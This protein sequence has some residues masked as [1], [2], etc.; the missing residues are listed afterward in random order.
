[1]GTRLKELRDAGVSIWLDDLSRARLRTGSL[2][3]LVAH[4]GVTGVT[5][6]PTIFAAAL[7]RGEDYAAQLRELGDVLVDRAIK[8][9]CA[10]D[11]R[12]ACDLLQD[13]ARSS[14]GY[15]GWVSIEV[16]PTLAHEVEGTVAE[17]VELRDLV[18]R[19]NV[20]VKIPATDEGVLA[21]EE[22]IA[23]GISVNVTLIFSVERYAQVMQAYVRGLE[24]ALRNGLSIRGIHSVASFFIS[25]VDTEVDR[26]LSELGRSDLRGRTAI[27]N[28]LLAYG[29]FEEFV[30]SPRFRELL[31]R[32]ANVQRPLW[33]STGTKDPALPDTIYVGE[34]A[35]PGVVN[36]MPEKT[37]RAFAQRGE[38]GP[39]VA[40]R[41]GEGRALLD[42][43]EAAGVDL[44]E[45]FDLLEVQGVEKFVASWGDLTTSVEQAMAS[46]RHRV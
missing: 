20:L 10:A 39:S 8:E 9:L 43:V 14:K 18:G 12:E 25:R 2:A 26:R 3:E 44:R 24:R 41:D 32:G 28:A 15:D 33:A 29:A 45:V 31:G 46:E 38:V 27:A 11:V 40:H 34:L 5:T 21:V 30:A 37:L 19:D 16:A 17:A 42:E 22:V 6:N 13:V 7:A 35:G 36:T 4:S 23:R 1:M